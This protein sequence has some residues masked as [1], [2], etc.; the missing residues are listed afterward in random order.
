ME[1]MLR[2]LRLSLLSIYIIPLVL[3]CY[4]YVEY[5][6]PLFVNTGKEASGLGVTAMLTFAVIVSILGLFVINKSVKSGGSTLEAINERMGMLLASAKQFEEAG[7]VDTLVE[8]VT[9]SAKDILDAEASALLLYDAEGELRFEHVEGPA[10]R[11]LK[12][13][14]LRPGEG[15]AGWAAREGRPLVINELRSDPRFFG[16]LDECYG[17]SANCVACAPLSFSGSELGLLEVINKRGGGSFTE[18]DQRALASLAEHASA[19]I[20]RNKALEENKG[21]FV[22][23]LDILMTA[24]DNFMPEKKGHSSRVAHY[25][26]KLAKVLG[27]PEEEVR[28]VYFGALLHDV[29]LMKYDM[30]EYEDKSR[31]RLHPA[32]GAEMVKD[33]AQWKDVAPIIREHHERYDGTGYPAGLSGPDI[34][35]GA[36]IVSLAEAFDVMTSQK[37]YKPMVMEFAEAVDD[38]K[39]YS[40]RQFDPRVVEAFVGSF[41]EDDVREA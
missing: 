18:Q 6:Y 10:A 11:T 28:K 38:I 1:K 40:G 37:S 22:H 30:S 33:I 35:F 4:L 15:I 14:A 5:V 27:L 26:V 21:D 20:Y 19:A 34:A 23:V 2:A 8:S 12:G 25:S 32:V 29:G 39:R 13:K 17:L 41:R 24:L 36:R 16:R 9:S 31:Y 7:Y 3:I